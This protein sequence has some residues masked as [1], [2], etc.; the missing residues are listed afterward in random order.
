MPT[1]PMVAPML[2]FGYNSPVAMPIPAVA[3]ASR[4]SACRTS[5]RRLSS[6]APSPT[7]TN[8]AIFGSSAQVAV[9]AGNWSTGLASSIDRRNNPA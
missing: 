6:A 8:W 4:R 3:A 9:P 7:G 1:V 5:G 2:M